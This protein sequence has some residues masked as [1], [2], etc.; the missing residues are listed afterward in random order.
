MKTKLLFFII[1]LLV[2]VML[3][4]SFAQDNTQVGL[5]EGAIA[6]LGKGGINIIK[7]SPDGT[8]LAIGTSIGVWIYN[9]KNESGRALPV[10][11]IR[12]FN[13]LVFSTDGKFLAAGGIIN[14]G[15][16]IWDTETGN[17]ISTIKLPDRFHRVSELTFSN[18]NKAIVGLGANRY[19]TEWDVNTGKEISQKEVYFSRHVHA[20]SPDGNSFVSGH[21]EN[22]EI[23]IWITESGLYG[24]NFQEKI[25]LATVAPLPS[26]AVDNPEKR[27]FIGGIQALAYSPDRK[28]IVSA[29]NNH[30]I[31]IWDISTKLERYTLKG[32]TEKINAVAFSTDSKLVASG[33]YDNTI[34]VWNV[35]T[36]KLEDVLIKHKNSI[37]TLAFSPTENEFLVSGSADGT[38]RFWDVN[39]GQQR[40]IFATGFTESV[41]ALA[42]TEDNSILVSTADTGTIQ[43]W[44]VKN[45]QELPFGTNMHYDSTE[46][47]VFSRDATLFAYRGA[48]TVTESDGSGVSKTIKPQKETR[49]LKLPTRTELFTILH[50]TSA[51]DIS[52]DNSM[53]AIGNENNT[54]LYDIESKE[55]LHRFDSSHFFYRNAICFSP[56]NAI[57]ATGGGPGEISLWDVKTGEKLDTLNDPFVGDAISFVFTRDG[58]ILAAR[59]SGR[60]RFWDMN[61]R[62]QRYTILAEKVILV[63]ILTFSPDG[64]LLLTSKWNN[65]VGSQIQ[66]WDVN[67][68]RELYKLTGHYEKIETMMF[69]HDGKVLATGGK[70]GSIL[71]WDWGQMLDKI[72][73]ENIGIIKNKQPKTTKT[74]PIYNSKAEEAQAVMKWLEDQE[75]KLEKIVDKCKIT[76]GKSRVMMMDTRGG[77][78]IMP[79]VR[80]EFSNDG[81][82]RIFDAKGNLKYKPS[83][84]E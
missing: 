21:Q 14:A 8:R 27:K 12:Y 37:K 34:H 78:M 16:Q 73:R 84:K 30:C 48:E 42:F 24:N 26:F 71:L 20:F 5:P 66:L 2:A 72:G 61:T 54:V 4:I 33:S 41:K 9:V 1:L 83:Y 23:R 64:K 57:L 60:V 56:D 53:I 44:D 55:E 22:G 81:I 62:K 77:A 3:P 63:D 36:G 40:S 58:S 31:R 45:G 43:M 59:Y 51:L 82:L 79:N 10:G 80:F 6:R 28:T 15:I 13:T 47:A 25:D 32:H 76:Q 38:V 7:F 18:G 17:K 67:A 50:R 19:I 35:E 65:K 29:H 52:D 69:S 70:D 39:T 74:K 46:A 75:Y 11:N 49:L 68:E